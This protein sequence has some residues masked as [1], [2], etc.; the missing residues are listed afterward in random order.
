MLLKTIVAG[1]TVPG[2]DECPE[3][4]EALLV[5][6]SEAVGPEA[7]AEV[8]VGVAAAVPPLW[9]TSSRAPAT[10]MSSAQT[11]PSTT[12]TFFQTLSSTWILL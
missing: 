2:V 1:A 9:P 4:G 8:G 11:T 3:L 10:P 7:T 5:E 6:P 12:E